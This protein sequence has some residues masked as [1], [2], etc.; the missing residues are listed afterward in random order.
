MIPL[1][2]ASVLLCSAI[3]GGVLGTD[4]DL[5][6]LAPF[7]AKPLTSWQWTAE[8]KSRA[9]QFSSMT[10]IRDST[11]GMLWTLRV[12]PDIPF[13][14]P[15]LETL[16][17]GIKYFPPEA[18]A[19]RMKVKAVSGKMI[20][21][22]GGPTAYF[23]NSD[24]FLRP[25]F[26]DASKDGSEWRTVEF[27]L[28][29]GLLRNFRR[30]GFSANAPWIYYARWAQEPTRF[31]VFKGSGGE[32]QIKDLEIVT[33]GIAKPFPVFAEGEVIPVATLA[34]FQSATAADKA[35]TAIVGESGKE[36]DLSWKPAEKIP[37][38][39]AEIQIADDREAGR[40]LRSRGLF[41]EETS[42]VGVTLSDPADGDGLLFRIRADTEAANMM[43]PAVP[44]QPLDFLIYEATD[45]SAF[46][47]QPFSPS[48]GL[49]DGPRKGYDRNLTYDKLKGMPGLSLAVYHA[50]RFVPKGQWCDLAIPFADFLCIYGS[51]DLS[52]SFQKQLAPDPRKLLAAAVLASWPRK[53]RFETSIDI[54]KVS[55][56]KFQ[57][58]GGSRRS[59]FQFADPAGN[60][61]VKSRQGGYSILLAPGE[62]ELPPD[63]K[64]LLEELDSR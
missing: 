53:G 27:S 43:L 49:L 4:R 42:A 8:E 32:I 9:G 56:V 39:P 12:S 48:R 38:P 11:G 50:R 26:L 54:R 23:G 55:L 24:A 63:L 61:S 22:P 21:G 10:L 60:R 35:F 41:L 52:A 57:E 31:Y 34:D 47:W 16:D 62:T 14:R 19:I 33:K 5:E 28:H 6:G 30:A 51:G 64:A 45:P 37:H 29:E 59:Y 18:D 20:I 17:L 25:V 13:K 36:F 2:L 3:G 44:C 15:Y 40:V 1:F 46:D 58:V 7:P